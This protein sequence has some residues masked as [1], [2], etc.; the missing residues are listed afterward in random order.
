[1]D[2]LHSMFE[3]PSNYIQL[4]NTS[5]IVLATVNRILFNEKSVYK[6]VIDFAGTSVFQ[7]LCAKD[8]VIV[9]GE[10]AQMCSSGKYQK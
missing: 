10:L 8:P 2:T 1:M 5:K 7:C 3:Y 4:R 6:E 9:F